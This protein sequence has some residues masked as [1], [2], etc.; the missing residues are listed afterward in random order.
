MNQ[1]K[2][3]VSFLVTM[4]LGVTAAPATTGLLVV[5]VRARHGAIWQPCTSSFPGGGHPLI[6]S[7]A[8]ELGVGILRVTTSREHGSVVVSARSPGCLLAAGGS[9]HL[10]IQRFS[11][12][13]PAQPGSQKGCHSLHWNLMTTMKNIAETHELT[14]ADKT[15]PGMPLFHVH[16]IKCPLF[17]TL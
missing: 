3:V 10:R 9:M 17:A 14:E 6:K 16:G 1:I 7:V 5:G 11:C 2:F 15:Y 12:V 4:W 8:T 13:P